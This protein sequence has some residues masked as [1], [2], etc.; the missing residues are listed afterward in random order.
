MN[1]PLRDTVQDTKTLLAWA[2][3]AEPGR[4]CVYHI[5][6][7]A[8][9]RIG[10]ETLA[11]LAETVLVLTATGW[12]HTSQHALALPTIR[13]WQYIATRTGG[14]YLP[15]SIATQRVTATEFRALSA[16]QHRQPAVSAM[17]AIR[18]EL[19]GM[20]GPAMQILDRLKA[21]GLV[22]VDLDGATRL[23]PAGVKAL[24]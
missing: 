5:G 19:G 10:S 6:N 20:D 1:R 9:D 18:E 11:R 17:R 14:G 15:R 24:V 3:D 13:G 21:K 8:N 4:W 23:T 7:L 2:A 16:V 22:Q 12:V